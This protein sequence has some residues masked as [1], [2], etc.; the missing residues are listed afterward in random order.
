ML[1]NLGLRSLEYRCY[2]SR[3]TMFYKTQY[4]YAIIFR[5]SH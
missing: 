2:D 1:S 5:A 4:G 3:L